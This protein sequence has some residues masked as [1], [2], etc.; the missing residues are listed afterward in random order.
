MKSKLALMVV[1]AVAV[2]S[3]CVQADVVFQDDF[4][5]TSLDGLKWTATGSGV[6]VAGS[7][8]TVTNGGKISSIDAFS[9]T[10][11]DYT[12]NLTGWGIARD[13]KDIFVGFSDA[14]GDNLVLFTTNTSSPTSLNVSMRSGGG[15]VQTYNIPI[16]SLFFQNNWT[17]TMNE[18]AV[19]MN[20]DIDGWMTEFDTDVIAP[21]GGGSWVIPT[22]DMKFVLGAAAFATSTGPLGAVSIDLV[23]AEIPEPASLVLMGTAAGLMAFRRRRA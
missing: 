4:P 13:T 2:Y 17:M 8:V 3:S 23:A 7:S 12:V 18:D 1:A 5:G 10:D 9:S 20:H 16:N 6:S 11:G 15:T 19:T 14:A 22:A 21:A